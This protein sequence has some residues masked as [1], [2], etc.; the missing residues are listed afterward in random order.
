MP[1]PHDGT[2]ELSR[3]AAQPDK[4]EL[5]RAVI[6]GAGIGGLTAALRLHRAGIACKVYEQS[7]PVRE[8][9][10]G[11]NLLPHAVRVLAGLGLLDALDAVAVRT[12]ELAYAHRLGQAIV[13]R[14]C[15]LDAG[16]PSRSSRRTAAGCRGCCS[17]PC[18]SDSARRGAH[19]APAG[20][21]S[22]D[23]A[24]SCPVRRRCRGLG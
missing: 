8:L 21:V 20:R 17:T 9:G 24:G 16:F 15:G 1:C 14:P 13:R 3:C 5:M 11:I 2:H 10:V 12:T 19:R 18:G 23:G 22:Q 4:P 6:V 7:E